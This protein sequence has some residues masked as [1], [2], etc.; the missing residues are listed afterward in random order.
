MARLDESGMASAVA[1]AAV[2]LLLIGAAAL[3]QLSGHNRLAAR[4]AV[5]TARLLE[6]SRSAVQRAAAQLER[7]EDLQ[8]RLQHAEKEL[9]ILADCMP[10]NDVCYRVKGSYIPAREVKE[11]A[12]EEP[13]YRL[14][15]E[16]WQPSE[17]KSSL[18]ETAEPSGRCAHAAAIYIYREG[19]LL[20]LRWEK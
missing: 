16:S 13:A 8:R 5:Q 18:Q 20:F 3:L 1:L 7:D 11:N 14:E 2:S 9:L 15:A 19:R 17:E 10:G 12:G 6:A 4:E